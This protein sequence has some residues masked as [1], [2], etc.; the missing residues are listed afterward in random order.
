MPCQ[1]NTAPSC[2]QGPH[3]CLS[4]NR[5]LKSHTGALVG[6][7]RGSEATINPY[8]ARAQFV[9]ERSGQRPFHCPLQA[10]ELVEVVGPAIILH[11]APIFP[12]V[13]RHDAEDR[14]VDEFRAVHRF[15]MAEV[16]FALVPHDGWWDAQP[17]LPI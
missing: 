16:S 11:H 4:L 12:L 10:V 17:D 3:P 9:R 8:N 2:D 13:L 1:R 7:K 14:V 15:A 5:D 6:L